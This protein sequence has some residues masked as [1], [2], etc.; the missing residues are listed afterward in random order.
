MSQG[1]RE[2]RDEV[3]EHM[4]RLEA[5]KDF[6]I[7]FFEAASVP[8]PRTRE[9]W[10]SD[11]KEAFLDVV[12][13]YDMLASNPK[14]ER[15]D[16]ASSALSFLEMASSR[17]KQVVSELK[18]LRSDAADDLAQ[19]LE[20]AFDEASKAIS[21]WT[22]ASTTGPPPRATVPIIEKVGED[23]YALHCSACGQVAATFGI[24]IPKLSNTGEEVIMFEGI[25]KSTHF[26]MS[27]QRA[28][29]ENLELGNLRAL[30]SFLSEVMDGGLDAYCPTCDKVYCK[31][32]YDT[33]EEWDEGF[34]DCTY[35]TCPEGHRRLLDD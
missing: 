28:I 23:R 33:E 21:A 10:V 32:H 17:V 34:Y 3:R 12:A 35:G 11:A 2:G 18:V 27:N 20:D 14:G 16:R 8:D 9:M 13:A 4:D 7:G 15:D 1:S 19:K 30:H 6:V 31:E 22:G 29:F 25:T 24:E 5:I 26:D